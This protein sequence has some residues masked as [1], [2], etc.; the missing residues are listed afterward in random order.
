MSSCFE[1]LTRPVYCPA[2]GDFV[3]PAACTT[4]EDAGCRWSRASQSRRCHS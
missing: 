3:D 2:A 4:R 1:L